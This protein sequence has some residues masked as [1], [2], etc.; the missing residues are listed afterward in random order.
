MK[1]SST[2]RLLAL[3]ASLCAGLAASPVAAHA[4]HD[5]ASGAAAGFAHPFT[6]LDHLLALAS[7]GAILAACTLR[8]RCIG[9]TALG[10]ALLIGAMIGRQGV[11]F[12]ALEWVLALSVVAAGVMVATQCGAGSS[13]WLI[14]GMAGFALFHGYAHGAEATGDATAFVAAFLVASASILG[15]ALWAALRFPRADSLRTVFG[16]AVATTGAGMLL[17]A[18][19]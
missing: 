2:I 6:G 14:A 5:A 11:N 12:Q 19:M 18:A 4:G 8:M 7:A 13:H 1:K 15:G 9:A 16:L 3:V 10:A 17:F